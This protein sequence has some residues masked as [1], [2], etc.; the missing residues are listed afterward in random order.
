M[1]PIIIPLVPVPLYNQPYN[2]PFHILGFR[3]TFT[4]INSNYVYTECVLTSWSLY[5]RL[6]IFRLVECVWNVMAHAQKPDFF[7][8]RQGRIHLN[9]RGRQFSRLLAAEVC[10]SEVVMLGT[11]CSEV[12]WRVLATQSIRQFPLH[13]PSSA[14][15]CAIRFQLYSKNWVFIYFHAGHLRLQTHTQNI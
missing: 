12:V 3:V 10:A 9:R 4:L 2:I 14:S 5:W 15:P 11:T 7:F 1:F 6:C 13:V 8:R